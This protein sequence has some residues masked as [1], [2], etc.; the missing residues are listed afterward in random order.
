M[1]AN[2][3]ILMLELVRRLGAKV[4][5][6]AG[7]LRDLQHRMTRAEHQL[8][9]SAAAEAVHHAVTAVRLDRLEARL[10]R[11]EHRPNA[12]DRSDTA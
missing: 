7:E 10:D 8:A 3:D 11:I 1:S 5:A 6:L 2:Y 4:D 9:A 12:P